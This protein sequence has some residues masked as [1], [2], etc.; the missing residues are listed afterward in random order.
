[1]GY[2]RFVG[3]EFRAAAA[4]PLGRGSVYDEPLRI[5]A[6]PGVKRR[7][8][9][10]NPWPTAFSPKAGIVT[11]PRSEEPDAHPSPSFQP[12]AA[13]RVPRRPVR[14]ICRARCLDR[15]HPRLELHGFHTPPRE[16]T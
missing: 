2:A 11:S 3:T 13:M 14:D 15:G 8:T 4:R 1:M 12:P 6:A 16:P 9:C 5:P 10:M 7:I